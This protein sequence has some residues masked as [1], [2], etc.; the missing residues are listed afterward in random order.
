MGSLE[1]LKLDGCLSCQQDLL[2]Q[3]LPHSSVKL[4]VGLRHRVVEKCAVT[5]VYEKGDKLGTGTYGVVRRAINKTITGLEV[6]VKIFTVVIDEEDADEVDFVSKTT[7]REI[8]LMR[9][10][11]HPNIAKVLSI[12]F[13][14]PFQCCITM[15]LMEG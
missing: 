14:T 11:D 2:A 6:A 3:S 1:I 5:K 15:P 4:D 13:P 12:F 8:S 9:K 7:L 10:M